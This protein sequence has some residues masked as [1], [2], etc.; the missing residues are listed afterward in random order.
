MDRFY[1]VMAWSRLQLLVGHL[2]DSGSFSQRGPESASIGAQSEYPE[3]PEAFLNAGW[4]DD[5][6]KTK[7]AAPLLLQLLDE[8]WL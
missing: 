7:A 6:G 8:V 2:D 3:L 4:L 5:T 1:V